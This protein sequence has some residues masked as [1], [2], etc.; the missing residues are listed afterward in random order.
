MTQT[1]SPTVQCTIERAVLQTLAYFEVFAYPLRQEE[2]FAF[3]GEPEATKAQVIKKLDTL[4]EQGRIFQL[5]PFLQ[6]KNEASWATR[7]LDCNRRAD[8]FLPRAQRIARFIGMF[9]FVRGVFVS[10]SL[11]K[12]CMSQES[13]IDF[14]IVTAPGRLWLARTLL[15]VF[16]KVFLLNSHKYFCVNYFVDAEHLEIEEK[17]LFTA[18]ECVTLLPMWGR[19]YY[20][21]F[22]RA[23]AWAWQWYPH[24]AQRPISDVPPCTIGFPKKLGEK[25]WAGKPGAWLDRK[26]MQLTVSFWKRKFRHLDEGTFDLALKSR[27]GVSKHHP[28]HFQQKVLDRFEE[29]LRD[30]SW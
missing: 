26:A 8:A 17:N 5:G 2:V 19:E 3:C 7:R 24:M 10:G 13:D 18:T 22:C 9:P 4:V 14:F 27:R 21:D 16:K 25:V 11:S 30:L 28:L 20:Q 29:N 23:N 15:V 12:H 1:L 6:I